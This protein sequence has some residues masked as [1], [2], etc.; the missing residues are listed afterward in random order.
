MLCRSRI[1]HLTILTRMVSFPFGFQADQSILRTPTTVSSLS[2][3]DVIRPADGA[4]PLQTG[5]LTLT[6]DG[7]KD[8]QQNFTSGNLKVKLLSELSIREFLY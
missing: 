3:T 2:K 8:S 1:T 5:K 7:W 6:D 4:Q